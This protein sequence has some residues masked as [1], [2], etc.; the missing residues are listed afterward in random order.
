MPFTLTT[1]FIITI[2]NKL[3]LCFLMSLPL[4][5]FSA[6]GDDDESDGGSNASVVVNED[7]TTSYGSIFSAVD[8]NNFYLDYIKYTVEEGHLFVSGYDRVGFKGKAKIASRISYKG[9]TY[10]VLALGAAFKD[11]TTLTSITL[12]GSMTS[13][14]DDAFYGCT[15]LTS[16]TLPNGVA[17]IGYNSFKGCTGLTSITLPNS[18]T[19]IGYSAFCGCVGLLDLYCY[20]DSVPEA[21]LSP[22]KN[23]PIENVTLHVPAGSIDAYQKKKPWSD[24]KAIVAVE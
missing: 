9:N 10:E 3:L 6:C 8:A 20:A 4:V 14:G 19:F 17:S 13:I 5:F 11:C 21:K 23:T 15:N 7:G 2:M 22:F 18:L 12:P 1:I 16:I 24:F